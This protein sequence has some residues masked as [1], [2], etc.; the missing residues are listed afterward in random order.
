MIR[1]LEV[2]LLRL[3]RQTLD[4]AFEGATVLLQLQMPRRHAE[5]RFP[6]V[7]D[8]DRLVGD[9]KLRK[10]LPAMC[11]DYFLD[12]D[13]DVRARSVAWPHWRFSTLSGFGQ[14]VLY[15]LLPQLLRFALWPRS[16]NEYKDLLT[17]EPQPW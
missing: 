10:L 14:G 3:W 11:Y 13:A 5:S 17:C 16:Y 15:P 6:Y 2:P 7:K 8:R 12:A 9:D 4:G 1:L